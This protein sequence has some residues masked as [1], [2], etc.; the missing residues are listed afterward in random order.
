MGNEETTIIK[1]QETIKIVKR[2]EPLEKII[3]PMI[4]EIIMDH[5]KKYAEENQIKRYSVELGS[6][7][8]SIILNVDQ[9]TEEFT[10]R[11]KYMTHNARVIEAYFLDIYK[12]SRE[13]IY[14][15]TRTR[16]IIKLRQPLQFFL[17]MYGD[18]SLKTVGIIT[19]GKDHA[20]VFHAR[21]KVVN[22]IEKN[23]E[24]RKKMFV[25]DRTLA[26][27]VGVASKVFDIDGNLIIKKHYQGRTYPDLE[28]I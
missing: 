15:I 11:D 3:P 4:I 16:D 20:T 17:S 14:S 8:Q 5:V 7:T 28:P 13:E 2:K 10:E 21:K 23:S 18:M 12:L 6:V 22:K 27:T 26:N 24:Y 25:L 9:T 19:G 1:R